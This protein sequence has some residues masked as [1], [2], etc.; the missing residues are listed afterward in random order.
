MNFLDILIFIPLLWFG[1]KGTRNG[2]IME[3]VSLIS[4]ITG[5]YLSI[6]FSHLI[7]LWFKI[8]GDY[9]PVLA[10][11]ITFLGAVIGIYILGKSLES[12]LK[13]MSLSFVNRI[14]GFLLGLL[15]AFLLIGIGIYF[16]NKIDRYQ[17]ILKPEIRDESISYKFIEK[18]TYQLWPTLTAYC[19]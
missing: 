9:A 4:I 12:L 1:Y 3:I 6:H 18:T 14:A 19:I 10:F 11:A 16:W 13:K 2:F 5:I 17:K 15:K 7:C 8:E